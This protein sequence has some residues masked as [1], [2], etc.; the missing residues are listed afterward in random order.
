MRALSLR[1]IA[2]AFIALLFATPAQPQAVYE[3]LCIFAA[4][5][6]LP[7]I[8]ALSITASRTKAGPAAPAT[9]KIL[10]ESFANPVRAAEALN[11]Y[12]GFL[13]DSVL[14]DINNTVQQNRTEAAVQIL[15]NELEGS[16][17]GSLSV[18][19]DVRAAAQDATF[20]FV[21]AW[22][23]G[24]PATAPTGVSR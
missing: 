22:G 23:S 16:I 10:A 3:K 12:F 6:K 2:V 14:T 8:P 7:S 5:Q 21:C 19:I 17:K 18:E 9:A 13:S 24:A 1:G 15:T 4:A 11:Q 20:T